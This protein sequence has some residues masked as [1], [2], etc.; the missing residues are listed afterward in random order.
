MYPHL[1]SQSKGYD[2]N[3]MNSSH[4]NF[5]GITALGAYAPPE[6]VTNADLVARGVDTSDDWIQSRTG[7]KER[8][9][10]AKGEF[11]SDLCIQAV[12]D[13]V[14]RYGSRALEGVDMVIVA[15][16]TPDALFPQTSALVQNHFKLEGAGAFDLLA[17]CPGWLYALS[18]AAAYTKS[19]IRKKVLAIG[20]E[21]LT[22]II[23]WSDR[24][25]NV[26]F[27]DGA[28]ASIVE[29]VPDGYGFKSFVLGVDGEGGKHLHMKC[30][31]TTLPDGTPL[32]DHIYM[33][34]R[35][36]FK[37]AVRVMHTATKE[38]VAQAGLTLNDIEQF[39]PHQANYRIIDAAREYLELPHEKVV[40][41]VDRYGNT[42]AASIG[43]AL[44]EALDDGRIKD[45]SDVLMV[46]F[47][48]GL[49]W[50]SSVM[51]WV[52]KTF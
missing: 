50:A 29:A 32:S 3:D 16:S 38:A 39:I 11:T 30:I 20:A 40:A 5:V 17:A 52:D 2:P 23:D 10:A 42:S 22:K 43:L 12:Q 35:E 28:C 49:T 19:G 48:A 41:N 6:I 9:F 47:G 18:V 36:V 33:N 51:R 26:L 4:A 37:F 44:R 34:G 1:P 31:N 14:N 21:S 7:I 15:T 24:S 27:G 8:R 13:L 45:G 25:T 46:T